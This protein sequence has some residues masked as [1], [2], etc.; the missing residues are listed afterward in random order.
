MTE[1]E[2]L[3]HTRPKA[4]LGLLLGKASDRKLRLFCIAALRG[5]AP[6]NLRLGSKTAFLCDVVERFADGVVLLDEVR[7]LWGSSG[8]VS[9]ASWPERPTDWAFALAGTRSKAAQARRAL[10]VR[11]IFGNPFRPATFDPLW[12]APT[13][14]ALGQTAY[15]ERLLPQGNCTWS[16]WRCWPTPSKTPAATTPTCSAI[17]AGRDR[18]SAAGIARLLL[19]GPA[20]VPVPVPSSGKSGRNPVWGNEKSPLYWRWFSVSPARKSPFLPEIPMKMT[21]GR[22][23]ALH[24]ASAIATLF[25]CPRAESGPETPKS[26]I[27]E[28]RQPEWRS[29]AF[30]MGLDGLDHRNAL[31]EARAFMSQKSLAGFDVYMDQYTAGAQAVTYV[32]HYRLPNWTEFYR[33][34]H[35]VS[36]K[37]KAI[38]AQHRL[39]QLGYEARIRFMTPEVRIPIPP[40]I[41][42]GPHLPIGPQYR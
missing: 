5:A 1:A 9:G 10:H 31:G 7:R 2:W 16:G 29:K 33:F 19:S 12:R 30:S 41:P 40:Q 38:N 32:V 23:A 17:C 18:T 28:Y 35:T 39:E 11:C 8:S 3:G 26:W 22:M 27:V 13:V 25:L 34:G 15:N 20:Q 14:A 6:R 24:A 21:T 37:E 36:D 4:M 42:V